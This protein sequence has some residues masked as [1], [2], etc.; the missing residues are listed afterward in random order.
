[1]AK[2]DLLDPAAHGKSHTAGL[3]LPCGDMDEETPEAVDAAISMNPGTSFL[4]QR[5]PTMESIVGHDDVR[6][7]HN[8][9]QGQLRNAKATDLSGAF[10][11]NASTL[12]LSGMSKD[13]VWTNPLSNSQEDVWPNPL[14]PFLLTE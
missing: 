9:S 4:W 14:A 3:M 8:Y 11:K 7:V 1:L 5:S 12:C 13:D 6:Y 2:G 10:Q